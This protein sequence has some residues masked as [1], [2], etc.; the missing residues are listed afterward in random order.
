MRLQRKKTEMLFV[1]LEIRGRCYD[2]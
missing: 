1:H 2:F